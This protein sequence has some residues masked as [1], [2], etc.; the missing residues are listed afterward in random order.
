MI[1]LLLELRVLSKTFKIYNMIKVKIYPFNTYSEDFSSDVYVYATLPAI[2]HEDGT[3]YLSKK[4]HEEL[5]KKVKTE[6][7]FDICFWGDRRKDYNPDKTEKYNELLFEDYNKVYQV[8]FDTEEDFVT[9]F[10]CDNII[11]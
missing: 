10:L 3:L 5:T 6:Q 11:E 2:P 9:I 7:I 1:I 8:C 4:H